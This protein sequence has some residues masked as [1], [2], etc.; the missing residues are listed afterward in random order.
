MP[1]TSRSN[2]GRVDENDGRWFAIMK[3]LDGIMGLAVG[4]ALGVPVEFNSR[5]SLQENPVTNMRGY[6]TYNQPPGTW[7]D[8]T[9]M[10]LCLLDSMKNG[11]NYT[12]IMDKFVS[13]LDDAKYTAHGEVFDVGIATRKAIERYK[14][15]LEP[16][17]CGGQ[18][19]TDNGNGALMRILPVAF[20]LHKNN[21]TKGSQMREIIQN[22]CSLTHAHQ[23]SHIACTVYIMIAIEMLSGEKDV[24][25]CVRLGIMRAHKIYGQP[26]PISGEF[27]HFKRLC[28]IG[29]KGHPKHE[30]SSTGYVVHTLEAA[31]WCLL[32][33]YKYKDCVLTAVNLGGD[34]DTTAAVVGGLAGLHY[35]YDSIPE[36]WIN[37]L[38]KHD[39][40]MGTCLRAQKNIKKVKV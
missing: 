5:A 8:D 27:K 7:S 40:I 37:A 21:I 19:E 11:I 3:I 32:N 33:T 22:I 20:Y 15:G 25:Q 38:A 39:F 1:G 31:I 12:D 9:S 18:A 16:L 4:D 10:T 24:W 2:I 23:I 35:G 29:F 36:E 14:R 30:I 26:C 6:G 34:T 28:D 13:W 17:N